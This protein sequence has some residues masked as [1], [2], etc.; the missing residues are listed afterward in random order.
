MGGSETE[1]VANGMQA[2]VSALT[3]SSTGLTSSNFF[4]VVADLVPF[5]VM[6]VPVALG[7]YFLR[8]LIKGAGKA[9]VRM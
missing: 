5:I 1:V 8:K 6:I 7:V 9:K 2:V 4:G 3:N